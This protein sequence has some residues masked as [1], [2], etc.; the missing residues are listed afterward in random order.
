MEPSCT[1]LSLPRFPSISRIPNIRHRRMPIVPFA[2]LYGAPPLMAILTNLGEMFTIRPPSV[3]SC[4]GSGA[5][6]STAGTTQQE[7]RAVRAGASPKA[8]GS[9]PR[10][11]IYLLVNISKSTIRTASSQSKYGEIRRLANAW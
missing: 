10:I 11:R 8:K 1:N 7:G 5:G 4:S 6:P 9:D 3:A 2:V